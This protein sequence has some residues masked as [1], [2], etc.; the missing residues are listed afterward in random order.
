MVTI[1]TKVLD[2]RYKL[3]KALGSGGFGRTYIA[4][5]MRRPGDPSCVV[6]HLQP[7]STDPNFV[8]EARRLFNT[9]AETLEKLGNHAQIPQL[10]AYFEEEQQFYLVQEFIE[11][12][13]LEEEIKCKGSG[14]EQRLSEIEVIAIL[15][16]VL[17]ILDF[18]HSEGVIHRDLKPDNI[19]RRSK[20]GKL[21]LIDFG[22]V[23]A[24]QGSATE[25]EDGESRFTVTIGTPGYMPS[26][27]SMGRPNFTSDIYGLGMI[28]INALTGLEPMDIP[29][30]SLT[31]ELIWRDRAK[32]TNLNGTLCDE[33]KI[34]NG[35]AIVLTRMVRYQY[36][37]RYQSAKE[38]LQALSAFVISDEPQTKKILIGTANPSVKVIKS[39]RQSAE[40]A[41]GLLVGG[42][43]VLGTATIFYITSLLN[44]PVQPP[45]VINPIPAIKSNPTVTNSPTPALP[46]QPTSVFSQSL[47][48]QVGQQVTKDGVLKPNQ[49]ISYVFAG[50]EKQK[51]TTTISGAGI[52]M[53]ILAPNGEPVD[54]RA[55]QVNNW[56]G[57]LAFTGDYKIQLKPNTTTTEPTTEVTPESKYVL[58][59]F[60]N[61]DI[62]R[63]IEIVPPQQ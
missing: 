32:V 46:T 61:E 48:I 15:R 25:V 53:T 2:G 30:D 7:A 18:V 16:D 1:V 10:L 26:E 5:D 56:D 50:K 29:T 62:P 19:I 27:Q 11:G 38:V 58:S 6:K 43:F 41:S 60:L 54:T 14:K 21:I 13:S 37:Q 55:I 44:K 36:S 23:K 22:A 34:S 12:R 3:I 52:L 42:L 35:L 9:E 24:V 47:D 45:I 51:L 59:V 28:A 40:T 31:G 63:V 8:R 17:N 39:Q 4:R 57:T 49:V 33:I 20:D